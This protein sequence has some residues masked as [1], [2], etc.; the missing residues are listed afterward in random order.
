MYGTRSTTSVSG[1]CSRSAAAA[2][3]P[4]RCLGRLGLGDG[5]LTQRVRRRPP[6]PSGAATRRIAWNPGSS[7]GCLL[8][9]GFRRRDKLSL[10]SDSHRR[11][12][13]CCRSRL[14][15]AGSG[16]C[17]KTTAR[18]LASLR[19]GFRTA[20]LST[21]CR[22][23]GAAKALHMPPAC[24]VSNSL[25][26]ARVQA[27]EVVP[28]LDTSRTD[29]CR[30]MAAQWMWRRGSRLLQRKR[31]SRCH[32]PPASLW[33]SPGKRAADDRVRLIQGLATSG[34]P[35]RSMQLRLRTSRSS[36]SRSCRSTGE[37]ACCHGW[38][39]IAA[40]RVQG[41]RAPWR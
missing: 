1:S 16:R 29:C 17:G 11:R 27:K 39:E 22:A 34:S 21:R 14:R 5:A 9:R 26:Q 24:R 40:A 31:P 32:V 38:H 15:R 30:L 8:L 41:W 6:A 19:G 36:C 3:H 4:T 35:K 23:R 28:S 7:P 37:G 13:R 25:E 12:R 20:P 33:S 10:C 18:E 2:W